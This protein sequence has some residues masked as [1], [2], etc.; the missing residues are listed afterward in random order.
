MSL[1]CFVCLFRFVG[2][3]VLVLVMV[4]VDYSVRQ[5]GDSYSVSPDLCNHITQSAMHLPYCTV[6]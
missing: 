6:R 2:V 5:K 4:M 3:V 1:A